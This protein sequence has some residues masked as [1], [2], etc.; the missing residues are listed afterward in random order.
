[1]NLASLN[2]PHN[3]T[4][5]RLKLCAPDVGEFQEINRAILE[6]Y[7]HLEL[8]IPWA[9]KKPTVEETQD[10]ETRTQAKWMTREELMFNIFDRATEQFAGKVGLHRINWNIPSFEIGYWIRKNHMNKGFATEATHALTRFAFQQ[11]GAKRVEIRCSSKNEKSIAIAK[12]LG[13][14]HEGCLRNSIIDPNKT[15][16]SDLVILARLNQKGLA[17]LDVSWN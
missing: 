2:I 16:P 14:E 4:A 3:I 17:P 6:T 5:P 13:F 12:K 11:L 9:T 8:W 7:D 10:A 1:M 15:E